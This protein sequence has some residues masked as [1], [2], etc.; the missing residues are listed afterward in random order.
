MRETVYCIV[1]DRERDA[2]DQSIHDVVK[3]PA[4][5][6]SASRSRSQP[7]DHHRP[8]LYVEDVSVRDGRHAVRH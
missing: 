8:R 7:H 5:S 1:E 6:A 4:A 2:V 3:A